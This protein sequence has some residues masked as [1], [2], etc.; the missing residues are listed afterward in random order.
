L[1]RQLQIRVHASNTSIGDVAAF[2]D[3][4]VLG[5]CGPLQAYGRL[6]IEKCKQVQDCKNSDQSEVDLAEDSFRHFRVG[7]WLLLDSV[8]THS[9][10]KIT[11]FATDI[12]FLCAK[13]TLLLNLNVIDVVR[14]AVKLLV[15]R[16]TCRHLAGLRVVYLRGQSQPIK[17]ENE[18]SIVD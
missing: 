15:K 4:S 13:N 14:R 10:L 16:I 8:N 11:S 18:S 9:F 2:V 7:H 6:T 5:L 1:S 17:R 12:G 3:R